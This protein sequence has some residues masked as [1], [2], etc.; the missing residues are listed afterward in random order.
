[1]R[2]LLIERD[3]HFHKN[4]HLREN[5]QFDDCLSACNSTLEREIIKTGLKEWTTVCENVVCEW[6]LLRGEKRERL[7]L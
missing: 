5:E 6:R 3:E 7:Q 4:M 2:E 1:M